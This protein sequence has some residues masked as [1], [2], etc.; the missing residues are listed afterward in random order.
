MFG[1]ARE[2]PEEVMARIW[3]FTKMDPRKTAEL[4]GHTAQIC[5]ESHTLL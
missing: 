4:S 3:D 5:A 2:A 1:E